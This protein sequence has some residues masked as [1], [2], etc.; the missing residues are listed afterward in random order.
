MIDATRVDLAVVLGLSRPIARAA[1]GMR[2][3]DPERLAALV[4]T[5][6]G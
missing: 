5:A 3:H 6:L 4:R 2:P 1:Y